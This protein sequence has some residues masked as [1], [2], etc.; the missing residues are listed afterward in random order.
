MSNIANQPR[1]LGIRLRVARTRAGLS[2]EHLAKQIGL[3]S[4]Y[5]LSRWE[6]GRQ[7]PK[8]AQIVALAG[9]LNVDVGWLAGRTKA[10]PYAYEVTNE[11][12][13]LELIYAAGASPEDLARPHKALFAH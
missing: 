13:D 10:A 2:Q 6:C 5:L 8:F 9:E 4:H 7:Y 12:G 11:F 1:H 3:E